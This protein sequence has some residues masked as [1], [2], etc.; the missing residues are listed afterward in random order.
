MKDG[1]NA[2]HGQAVGGKVFERIDVAK[3]GPFFA[4]LVAD[5]DILGFLSFE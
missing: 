4:A 3:L 1:H 2:S 5:S